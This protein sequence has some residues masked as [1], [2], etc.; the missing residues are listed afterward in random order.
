MSDSNR[1]T[2]GTANITD[3]AVALNGT[4]SMPGCLDS[5]HSR[6]PQGDFARLPLNKCPPRRTPAHS[7]QTAVPPKLRLVNVGAD[8]RKDWERDLAAA[9]DVTK[10]L[11]AY[12]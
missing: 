4:R 5:G 7:V 10:C 6:E 1:R 12:W 11:P 9:G 2:C 8:R 3:T